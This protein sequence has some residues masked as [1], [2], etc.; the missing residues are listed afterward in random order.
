MYEHSY[1][2]RL[3]KN[4]TDKKNSSIS[5]SPYL[6]EPYFSQYQSWRDKAL[7]CAEKRLDAHQDALILMLDLRSFFY[8]VHISEK[9]F[10][11]IYADFHTEEMPKWVKPIHDF[12]YS[13]LRIYSAKV[14]SLNAD[15][16]L[17]LGERVFLPIGFLPSNLLSNWF[18]TPFDK[19]IS[20]RINPVYY[21]RYVDDII[22]VDKVE[23]NSELRKKA[24]KDG[25]DDGKLT[26]QN[27]IQVYF[28]SCGGDGPIFETKQ[29]SNSKEKEDKKPKHLIDYK[30]INTI[31]AYDSVSETLPDVRVQDNKVKAFYFREGSTRALLDCF[32]A[33]IGRN[34]S[35]FRLLPDVSK[36][37]RYNDYSEIFRLEN[38]ETPNKLRGIEDLYIDRYSFSKFLGKYRKA[39]NMIRD[40]KENAFDRNLTIFMDGKTLIEH[41][42]FWERLFEILVVNERFDLVEKLFEK[43]YKAIFAYNV[44]ETLVCCSEKINIAHKTLLLTLRAALCRTL[45]LCWGPHI[46]A[47]LKNISE[48]AEKAVD[49]L[50]DCNG[51]GELR[52]A[53]CSTRMLDKYAMPIPLMASF[54]KLGLDS[55]CTINLCHLES[56]MSSR[57]FKFIDNEDRYSY[58][59]Y[60][61]RPQEIAYALLC[62]SMA[63][64]KS[65]GDPKKQQNTIEQLYFQFNYPE[66]ANH[67]SA[68]V[69]KEVDVVEYGANPRDLYHV[70]S[71]KSDSKSQIKIA[72]GNARLEYED[73]R[74]ALTDHP[75]RSL[76]RYEQFNQL[77]NAALKEK[78]DMLVLP[79]NYLPW[80]WI[81]DVARICANNQ[82][83]LVTGIE[84]ILSSE[85]GDKPRRAYNLTAI[86]LPYKKEEYPFAHIVCHHKTHY[87]PEEKR[88]ITG[89]QL[90]P[91]EG[92]GYQLFQWKD[93]WFSVYCCYEL[94]SI[95]DRSL[96]QSL[97]D[98]AIAVE[99][100]RDVAYFSNIIESMC[101]DLHCY[102]V[103]VNSSVYGDSRVMSPCATEKRDLIK[104][105]GGKNNTILVDTID[106]SA[107]RNFQR[108]EYELQHELKS[109]KPTP[110][111]FDTAMVKRK[112]NKELW[113]YL[114][115]KNK[116]CSSENA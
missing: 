47:L 21:G 75:N 52:K 84:H 106:I 39:G 31:F 70:I 49:N 28:C 63:D 44:P 60:I 81:P 42:I 109:F 107:L 11:S 2:N 34:A 87:S 110:P 86:I 57:G 101:R 96:F 105:K 12:I 79:E 22:I 99:W 65:I 54:D 46:D 13:V 85:R 4:L 23:K 102:C 17:Q 30:I 111:N 35:E 67:Q 29:I 3:R 24:C 27:V 37:L 55:T 80:E 91:L 104:T 62:Q 72:I 92:K 7:S 89:Y 69:F 93:M 68:K 25:N 15:N 64:G 6:F 112:Q 58:S 48:I 9:K 20:D 5:H 40:Q 66:M 83:A 95:K 51:L 108:M 71:V 33:E 114:E 78:A 41:Y 38:G 82:M 115:Q 14:R 56:M 61:V 116:D 19:A 59:P 53:Y 1:G 77:I 50:F 76:E 18:L 98:L 26:A 32:R 8:S 16:E 45:A 113:A 73:F 97:A 10:D 36:I 88:Q 74:K 94:A 90:L 103:Q 43:V 100:N